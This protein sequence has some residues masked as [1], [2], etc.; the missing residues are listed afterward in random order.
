MRS[1][2][3][4]SAD[5]C[6]AVRAS[7]STLVRLHYRR[8]RDGSRPRG[9]T[10]CRS[11]YSA[12]CRCRCRRSRGW[13]KTRG[14]RHGYDLRGATGRRVPRRRSWERTSRCA[15]APLP[16]SPEST[17]A[18]RCAVVWNDGR[19]GS[20]AS[21]LEVLTMGG[22]RAGHGNGTVSFHGVRRS[23]VPPLLRARRLRGGSTRSFPTPPFFSGNRRGESGYGAGSTCGSA[24]GSSALNHHNSIV[25]PREHQRLTGV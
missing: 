18:M 9:G 19:P 16:P 7:A 22:D 1:S 10:R 5:R 12:H 8:R 4:P 6:R 23:A 25:S 24:H 11:R 2:Y 20:V 15:V 17:S 13:Y 14:Q 3:A 21:P